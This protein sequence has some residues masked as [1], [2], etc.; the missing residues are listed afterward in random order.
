MILLSHDLIVQSHDLITMSCVCVPTVVVEDSGLSGGAIAGIIIAV[1]A[2]ILAL[3]GVI[4]AS[5]ILYGRC[6]YRSDIGPPPSRKGS[7]R[8]VSWS[9]GRQW[10]WGQMGIRAGRRWG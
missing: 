9:R 4:I 1:I 3:L 8:L 5:I 7:M 2:V 10:G 6:N